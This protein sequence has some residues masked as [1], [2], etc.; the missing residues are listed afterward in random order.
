MEDKRTWDSLK[1]P[2]QVI[3]TLDSAPNNNFLIG[4]GFIP[5]SPN[6]SSHIDVVAKKGLISTHGAQ[7]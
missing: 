5:S 4:F 7:N 3:V 1:Q 6:P 2:F